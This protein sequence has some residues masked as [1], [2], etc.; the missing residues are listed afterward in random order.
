MFIYYA[1]VFQSTSER[2]INRFCWFLLWTLTQESIYIWSLFL[3]SPLIFFL[4]LNSLACMLDWFWKV[5]ITSHILISL[6]GTE[7]SFIGIQFFYLKKILLR[8]DSPK[9]N[10]FYSEVRFISDPHP[11]IDQC[12]TAQRK[13]FMS[14][15]NS[16]NCITRHGLSM[17]M[18]YVY[19]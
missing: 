19:L 8:V 1:V 12:K 16:Q 6:T 9:A 18:G 10:I 3:F 11:F 4:N 13:Q 17:A 7:W 14:K 15:E 5:L 2:K